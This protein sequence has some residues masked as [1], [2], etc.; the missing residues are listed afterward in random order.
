MKKIN[1]FLPKYLLYSSPAVAIIFVWGFLQEQADA[2]GTNSAFVKI[3]RE[4][5]SLHLVF[6]FMVLIYV[7]ILLLVSSG[8][9]DTFLSKL[10]R[11]RE[12][13]ERERSIIGQSSR[14][15]FFSTLALLVVLFFF[16][17]VHI[18]FVRLPAEKAVNGKRNAVTIGLQFGLRD[19]PAP[20]KEQGSGEI[21]FS[22]QPF[23]VSKQVMVLALILWHM[24]TFYYLSRKIQSG[25]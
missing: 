10:A 2:M 20:V 25:E 22:T 16:L 13:D 19:T 9:R 12:R 5:L 7:L 14:F 4:A 8:F 3:L 11:I 18:T 6:W 1:R 17:T 23:P 15:A 24:G 21:V